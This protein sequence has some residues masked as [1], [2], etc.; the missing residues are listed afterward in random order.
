MLCFLWLQCSFVESQ[1]Y[2]TWTQEHQ[3]CE[4]RL[5][6]NYHLPPYQ[7]SNGNGDWSIESKFIVCED[8]PYIDYFR[9]V[10]LNPPSDFH[11][12]V[13]ETVLNLYRDLEEYRKPMILAKDYIKQNLPTTYRLLD[14]STKN[15][16]EF[17]LSVYP[18]SFG[19][20]EE[21]I[22]SQIPPKSKAFGRVIPGVTSTYFH[23]YNESLYFQDMGSSLFTITYKKAGWD[24]LRHYE[25]LASGSLPLFLNIRHCPTQ[26]MSIHPKKLYRLLLK[27]PGLEIQAEKTGPMVFSFSKLDFQLTKFDNYLYQGIASALLHYT[28]NVLSTKALAQY[29]LNTMYTNSVTL[30]RTLSAAHPVPRSLLYLTHKDNDMD[31]GDYMTD[32]LLHGLLNLL[33][34][35]VVMDFPSRDC[36]YKTIAHFNLTNYH[37]AR[38]QQYGMGFSFGLKMDVFTYNI[39]RN[40]NEIMLAIKEHKYDMVILGSGHRDG[41]ASKLFY[42]DLVCEHYQRDEVGFVDGGDSHLSKKVLDRYAP[43][44]KHLFS[45]EGY[46][47]S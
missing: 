8:M 30:Q 12:I 38:L 3:R 45:R 24:C 15:E 6:S 25:I 32:F 4:L 36:L 47:H 13:A 9:S 14:K 27:Y 19:I 18:I 39:D 21:N 28:H 31:K 22:V 43:C 34:R 16:S 42:W 5:P 26:A 1:Q 20:F 33:G 41:W 11:E 2:I 46:S 23:L 37:K 10:L 44:A 17:Q 40:P 29:V 7:F 35:K